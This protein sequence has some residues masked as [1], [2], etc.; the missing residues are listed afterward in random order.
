[1]TTFEALHLT[2]KNENI[3]ATVVDEVIISGIWIFFL[4]TQL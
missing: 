1:M 3:F 2:E 4:H